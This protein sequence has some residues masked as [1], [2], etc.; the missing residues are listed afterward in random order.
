MSTELVHAA[1][2]LKKLRVPN[3]RTMRSTIVNSSKR[4]ASLTHP[5]GVV[6]DLHNGVASLFDADGQFDHFVQAFAKV[7]LIHA[8]WRARALPFVA[9][10]SVR[11][12]AQERGR[13]TSEQQS[14]NVRTIRT[15]HPLLH[16][17][18][19]MISNT[20]CIGVL[21]HDRK[22]QAGLNGRATGAAASHG[23]PSRGRL[24]H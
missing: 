11:L 22:N 21:Q 24:D 15:P 3:S 8:P 13:Q 20:G 16:I 6:A 23:L 10:T 12:A 17:S 14:S 18:S 4:P 5:C 1:L 9:H 7:A 2:P 19:R